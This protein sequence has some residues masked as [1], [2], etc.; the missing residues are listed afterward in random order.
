LQTRLIVNP[1]DFFDV[2]QSALALQNKVN[3]TTAI[4]YTRLADPRDPRRQIRRTGASR[5]PAGDVRV[6]ERGICNGRQTA[7]TAKPHTPCG[8]TLSSPNTSRRSICVSAPASKFSFADILQHFTIQR[9]LSDD[10][11]K[12]VVLVFRTAQAPHLRWHQS[13]I[14]FFQLKQLSWQIRA[15]RQITATVV[16]SSPCLTMNAFC[17]SVNLDAF[18]T[19][20]PSPSQ[21]SNSGKL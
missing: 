10:P 5:C 19:S 8:L 1:A 2:H 18:I 13:R 17:A 12:T 9:Q 15:F 11:F 7:Q 20:A 3:A 4:P 16:P 21:E 6:A 14:V